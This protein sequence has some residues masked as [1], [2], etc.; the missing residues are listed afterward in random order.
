ML[1]KNIMERFD[2]INKQIDQRAKQLQ[3]TPTEL[4]YAAIHFY[5]EQAVDM[6]EH[7]LARDK[8]AEG[9]EISRCLGCGL[10]FRKDGAAL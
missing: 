10:G 3:M 1:Q 5:I 8:D 7:L 9:K 6:H 4:I 2:K